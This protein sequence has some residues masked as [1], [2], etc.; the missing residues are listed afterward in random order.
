MKISKILVTG[1]LGISLAAAIGTSNASAAYPTDAYIDSAN[2]VYKTGTKSLN[3]KIGWGGGT[4]SIYNVTW[5]DGLTSTS[6]TAN[7]YSTSITSIY[8][9]GSRSTYKWSNS[10]RVSNGSSD[11]AYGSVTL[12]R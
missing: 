6:F 7:Y 5:N 11:T 2:P 9:L 10:L 4:G 8:Q 3:R 1:I 12:K